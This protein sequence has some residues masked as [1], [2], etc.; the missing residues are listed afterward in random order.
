VLSDP[1][2]YELERRTASLRGGTRP[3][4]GF[5]PAIAAQC[6]A[7]GAE[8]DELTMVRSAAAGTACA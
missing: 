6:A 7:F 2:I 8:A 5:E 3:P 1:A 4:L